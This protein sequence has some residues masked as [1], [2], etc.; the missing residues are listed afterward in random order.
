MLTVHEK[1]LDI[2]EDGD[3]GV[4]M[5]MRGM[6][7]RQVGHVQGEQDAGKVSRMLREMQVR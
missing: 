4:D 7:E 5:V 1:R 3:K 2:G 6:W